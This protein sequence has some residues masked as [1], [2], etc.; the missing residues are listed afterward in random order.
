MEDFIKAQLAAANQSD[1][2]EFK[3][4]IIY[5]LIYI[6]NGAVVGWPVIQFLSLKSPME[7][8][9]KAR[10]KIKALASGYAE[11]PDSDEDSEAEEDAVG[12]GNGA[13]PDIKQA[14]SRSLVC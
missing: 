3:S 2:T 4:A 8:V 9:E 7:L 6:C 12:E 1:N 13:P 11:D 14:R 10:K 5:A